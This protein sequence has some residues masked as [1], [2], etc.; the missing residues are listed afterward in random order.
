MNNHN[1]YIGE[2]INYED[3]E[4]ITF[5]DLLT[6]IQEYNETYEYALNN[7]GQDFVNGLMKKKNIEDYFDG[8]KNTNIIKFNYCPVC[9]KEIQWKLMKELTKQ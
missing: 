4:L 1:C 6:K 3:K 5:K 7:Y 9:G 8:R 2:W